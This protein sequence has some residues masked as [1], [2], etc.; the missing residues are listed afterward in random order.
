M[1]YKPEILSFRCPTFIKDIVDDLV[2]KREFKG[3]Q[4]YLYNLLLEDLKQRG[5]ISIQIMPHQRFEEQLKL[6]EDSNGK[7]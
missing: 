2:D 6:Q 5:K 7:S 4:E 3:R 1:S